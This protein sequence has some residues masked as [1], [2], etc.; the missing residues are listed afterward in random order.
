MQDAYAD[1]SRLTIRKEVS[2][3]RVLLIEKRFFFFCE[4]VGIVLE[5]V[6]FVLL[7]KTENDFTDT[8][9]I[10][11]PDFIGFL[12][13]IPQLPWHDYQPL[14]EQPCIRKMQ[15]SQRHG[16]LFSAVDGRFPIHGEVMPMTTY[17]KV[18]LVLAS[19]QLLAAILALLK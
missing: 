12:V 3:M 14:P 10:F 5:Q 6:V 18:A 11:P 13:L 2:P 4:L 17:E 19:L 7:V 16:I 8:I 1:S 9:D 15:K